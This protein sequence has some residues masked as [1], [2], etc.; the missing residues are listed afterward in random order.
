MSTD[1]VFPAEL[2]REIFETTALM[3]PK[4]IPVLLRVTRRVHIWIEPLLYRVIQLNRLKTAYGIRRAMQTNPARFFQDN[5]R[6]L[7]LSPIVFTEQECLALLSV[8]PKLV[9]F[10]AFGG[11]LTPAMLPILQDM[12]HVRR[13]SSRLSSLFGSVP[14]IDL[15]IPFFRNI[16][17]IDIFEAVADD[18]QTARG[19]A[20]L[21]ALTHVGLNNRTRAGVPRRL[22]NECIHL[23]VLANIWHVSNFVAAR[24]VA[25]SP[26][27]IDVRFV[28]CTSGNHCDEWEV[29]ARGGTDFWAAAD[30]FVARKRRG[31]IDASCYWV[32]P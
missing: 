18:T 22:L 32:G 4:T 13:W 8:C 12:A 16:T 10:Y 17:H 29:G 31:E 27:A 21:P 15:S 19:L 5:V 2:E 14:A 6:H 23:Q 30:A 9:S 26:P 7:L 1:P 11:V 24:N 28:V 25:A 3:H 20:A